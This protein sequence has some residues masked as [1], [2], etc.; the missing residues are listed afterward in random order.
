MTLVCA[1]IVGTF[2]WDRICTALFAPKIFGAMFK[3]AKATTLKDLMPV[4]WS[5][6]KVVGGLLI[7][8]SGNIL[9][10]GGCWWLRRKYNA[11]AKAK[12]DAE[13]EAKVKQMTNT[14]KIKQ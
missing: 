4:F 12:N 7:M 6:A 10:W 13:L 2:I 5:L 11:M 9:V 1:S 3:S 8:S 14:K